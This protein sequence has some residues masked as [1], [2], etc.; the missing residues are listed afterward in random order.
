MTKTLKVIDPFLRL[1]VGDLFERTES[2]DYMSTVHENFT[3]NTDDGKEFTTRYSANFVISEDYAEQMVKDGY[4]AEE[5][6]EAKSEEDKKKQGFVNVFDEI[7][8]LLYKFNTELNEI[9]N[10]KD[11]HPAIA[12]EG[13]VVY[14]NLITVLEHLKSLK[15]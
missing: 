3:N 13:E 4:L 12:R 9:K 5:V 2:G 10:S 7:N 8:N 11:I 6:S 1:D 15:K 14:T